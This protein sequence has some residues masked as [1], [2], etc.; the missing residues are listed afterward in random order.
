MM[1]QYCGDREGINMPKLLTTLLIIVLVLLPT[2]VMAQGEE[3][4]SPD[5]LRRMGTSPLAA[6]TMI[7]ASAAK[8]YNQRVD[9]TYASQPK[10]QRPYVTARQVATMMD[11]FIQKYHQGDQADAISLTH[12]LGPNLTMDEKVAFIEKMTQAY[13]ADGPKTPY[14]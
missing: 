9:Q 12:I 13:L 14:K 5:A 7:F 8:T 4:I 3:A 6:G 10:A 11:G 2:V 1:P